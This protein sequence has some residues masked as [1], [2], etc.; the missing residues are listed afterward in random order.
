MKSVSKSYPG[1]EPLLSYARRNNRASW[2]QFKND[3][4]QAYEVTCAML[5][6]DQ[7]GLCA[8]CEIAIAKPQATLQVEH[9]VAKSFRDQAINWGLHWP[10]MIAVCSGGS[11][12]SKDEHRFVD[13]LPL[14]L[15]CDQHKNHL[16]NCNKIPEDSRGWIANPL[17]IPGFPRLVD[18]LHD[19]KLKAN[20]EACAQVEIQP[21]HYATTEEL[22]ANTIDHLNLN[23]YRLCNARVS[24]HKQIVREMSNTPPAQ[25]AK[26]CPKYLSKQAGKHRQFF[27]VF[28]C[29]LG[30]AAE[31]FLRAAD[32]A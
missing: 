23:C 5:E 26:L 29:R 2:D 22:I 12:Y 32:S 20:P 15:S 25:R 30:Q 1:P 24:A 16:V 27:T 17:E 6:Q 9:L 13:D 10:N 14:N 11:Q 28:R 19:G 3:D 18:V 8:Y 7:G 4:R 31:A 21:N